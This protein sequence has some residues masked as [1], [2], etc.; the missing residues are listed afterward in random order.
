MYRG[1][2][3]CLLTA[4]Y[5]QCKVTFFDSSSYIV[6]QGTSV[7]NNAGSAA[8]SQIATGSLLLGMPSNLTGNKMYFN[9][10]NYT[11]DTFN[12]VMT[13]TYDPSNTFSI[14]MVGSSI[15][16]FMTI[17]TMYER[18]QVQNSNNIIEGLPV[19]ANPTPIKLSG[20]SAALTMDIQGP[21]NQ[22]IL[23]ASTLILGGDLNLEDNVIVSG[24]GT[25][26]FND[27]NLIVGKKDVLWTDTLT[28]INASNLELNS[29][30]K[31]RGTWNFTG[32]GDIVGNTFTLD[33]TGGGIL[34]IQS[35]TTLRM[36][37]L[38][39]K[40][41]G[42]GSI[43]FT[44]LTSKLQ[45]F[46]VIIDMDGSK[47]FTTGIVDAI[48]PVTVVTGTNFLTFQNRA[49][50]TVD[51]TT[52]LYNTL[53]FNNQNNIRFQSRFA[54][55][56]LINGG[57]VQILVS[58]VDGDYQIDTN[59]TLDQ[60]LIVSTLNRLQINQS[61]TITGAGFEF[62]FALSSSAA[63][64]D[65]APVFFIAPGKTATFQNI[66]LDNFP[67]QF[68]SIPASS[69]LIFGDL[70]T[71]NLGQNGTLTNTWMF[72]GRTVLNGGGNIMQIGAA[73]Q[74]LL[75]PGAS[76]LLNNIT[77]QDVSG[78]QIRCMDNTSTISFGNI[79]WKQDGNFTLSNGQFDVIGV[80]E[81][82]GTSTFQYSGNRTCNITSFGTMC[83]DEGMA[84]SYAPRINN[85]D[86]IKM[87]NVDSTLCFNSAS[88]G[89]TVTGMRL[90]NGTLMLSGRCHMYNAGAKALSQGISFGNNISAND[91]T[92]R[93]LAQ[94]ELYISSG[95]FVYANQN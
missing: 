9:K 16:N 19:F 89:S 46:N 44:D 48:G 41:L 25:I 8:Q 81:F 24:P 36:T 69:Q 45:L 26:K 50:L 52:V 4:H 82:S 42:S 14:Q 30:N 49:T 92:V 91:L 22:N 12:V 68:N 27:F 75:R 95:V 80:T 54:N 11:N 58:Q 37:N 85:R 28:M 74:I 76:L 59:T 64:P 84:F 66:T 57:S 43:V 29:T 88:I 71:V 15:L 40:G 18:I 61:T 73:G 83:F 90:T 72:Q 1:L 13:A 6:S 60:N 39:L 35:G 32:A 47:T 78:N 23:L 17:G 7:F 5:A 93:F 53:S 33:L 2:L 34:R 51:G 65:Q 94:G 20:A 70:T 21:L 31:L 62:S 56:G 55:E 63:N 38:I 3:L 10:G 79:L 77:L 86:L 67:I 87:Q